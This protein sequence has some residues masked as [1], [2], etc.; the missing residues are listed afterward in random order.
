MSKTFKIDKEELLAISDFQEREKYK[1]T[2][3]EQLDRFKSYVNNLNTDK[4]DNLTT[5]Q[6]RNFAVNYIQEGINL[7]FYSYDVPFTDKAM[8]GVE[9][10]HKVFGFN[11]QIIK[12]EEGQVK[13]RRVNPEDIT[14]KF[15]NIELDNANQ[16]VDIGWSREMRDSVL[17][18]IGKSRD[19]SF[20]WNIIKSSKEIYE[21]ACNEYLCWFSFVKWIE[22]QQALGDVGFITE[23]SNGNSKRMNFKLN[24][25]SLRIIQTVT[26]RLLGKPKQEVEQDVSITQLE[27]PK[28]TIK[29]N[30]T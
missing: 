28:I 10:P 21:N 23:D 8:Q 20:D 14:R 1:F 15:K 2:K 29:G 27:P 3:E 5:E 24:K 22:S 11:T 17:K 13:T 30:N 7:L 12:K 4:L 16:R 19:P 26:E 25:D 18:T 9:L 6:A